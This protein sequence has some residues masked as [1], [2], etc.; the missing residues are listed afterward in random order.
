MNKFLKIIRDKVWT[1]FLQP[2]FPFDPKRFPFFYGW[3]ILIVSTIGL[4]MS[5]PGQ[6]IGVSVFTDYLIEVLGLSRVQIS[7]A[8][9]LGTITS[10]FL[11]P[12]SGKLYDRVGARLMGMLCTTLLAGTL[13]YLS[14]CD[15]VARWITPMEGLEWITGF[16]V[17][18]LGFSLVRFSGQGMLAMTTRAMLGKWFLHKRGFVSGLNGMFAT[19]SFS[20]APLGMNWL[21]MAFDWRGAWLLMGG[22]VLTSIVLAWLT[23]RDNPE[24]CGLLMD[25]EETHESLEEVKGEKGHPA[26]VFREFTYEEA[27]RTYSFWVFNFGLSALALIIT[28]VTFHI[29]SIGK[30]AGLDRDEAL[31]I[32]FPMALCSII[33]N[34]MFGRLSDAF[35]MK[36][37]LMLM[38]LGITAGVYGTLIFSTFI[39][40]WLMILGFGVGQ[41]IFSPLLTMTWPTFFGREHLGAISSFSLSCQV[42]ASA[43]GPFLLSAS[44]EW[45]GS[46]DA[47]NYICLS[48]PL[49]LLFAAV[50]AENPQENCYGESVVVK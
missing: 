44:Y 4:V 2:D 7:T 30:S 34:L 38:L 26:P 45:L 3:I 18:Y 1:K 47:G 14:Q 9:M 33:V 27:I 37:L 24:E 41:G 11:L 50:K 39:G 20:I 43:I 15:R 36:Y 21:V 40:Q 35:K 28:A 31:F 49:L 5:V 8:Y 48:I 12:W 22:I 32:F 17:I 16:L 10:S 6:T 13:I 19:F 23:F 29:V 42:F 25:G 46:Y